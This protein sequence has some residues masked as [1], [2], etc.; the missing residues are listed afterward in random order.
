[1][2]SQHSTRSS[3]GARARNSAERGPRRYADQRLKPAL[4]IRSC[5]PSPSRLISLPERLRSRPPSHLRRF[6]A[7]PERIAVSGCPNFDVTGV[8]TRRAKFPVFP[9]ELGILPIMPA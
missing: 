5:L 3:L 6:D 8:V 9:V 1:M 7:E 2:E 4:P